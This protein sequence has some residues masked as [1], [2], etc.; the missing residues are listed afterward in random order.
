MGFRRASSRNPATVQAE[1]VLKLVAYNLTRLW[2]AEARRARGRRFRLHA[3]STIAELAQG[4]FGRGRSGASGTA[5]PVSVSGAPDDAH[6]PLSLF[7]LIA[8]SLGS[9]WFGSTSM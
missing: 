2:A 5:H 7:L 8:F 6:T 4:R 1:I 9:G 3:C